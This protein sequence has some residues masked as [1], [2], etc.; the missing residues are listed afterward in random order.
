[1]PSAH[2]QGCCSYSR[3]GAACGGRLWCGSIA[4]RG[5]SPPSFRIRCGRGN[6]L[7]TPEALGCCTTM[8]WAGG[9]CGWIRWGTP[10]VPSHSASRR[11]LQ[12]WRE[13]STWGSSMA[14]A[15]TAV[16]ARG[17]CCSCAMG[18]WSGAVEWLPSGTSRQWRCG[19]LKPMGIGSGYGCSPLRVWCPF[20]SSQHLL[21][22]PTAARSGYGSMGFPDA[23][24][25]WRLKRT[26][27]PGGS[28]PNLDRRL[29]STP[30]SHRCAGV[31][32]CGSREGEY[33][34]GSNVVA[35]ATNCAAG[36]PRRGRALWRSFRRSTA[37][38]N[39]W[40]ASIRSG[41]CA[42]PGQSSWGRANASAP[43]QA[44]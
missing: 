21:S 38:R 15:S 36:M 30:C 43:G 40:R 31:L 7:P 5:S 41:W 37:N 42:S 19:G 4:L 16:Q 44:A 24:Q 13:R 33:G 11:T 29:R 12:R 27:G 1:M 22:S 17:S 10:S 26:R 18:I 35:R 3:A 9:E 34:T 25:R 32:C 23:A 2:P 28:C 6:G 14:G 8:V 20:G 39:G